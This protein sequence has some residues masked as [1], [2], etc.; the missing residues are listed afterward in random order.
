MPAPSPPG[1]VAGSDT[2]GSPLQD[3]S[4]AVPGA[5]A[6]CWDPPFCAA[7][8]AFC[9]HGLGSV[10][11]CLFLPSHPR[12]GLPTLPPPPFLRPPVSPGPSRA[13]KCVH[14]VALRVHVP[15]PR[16]AC[17]APSAQL[18]HR[19][20]QAPLPLSPSAVQTWSLVQ[21]FPLWS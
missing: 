11:V 13:C 16:P 5:R 20:D 8:A 21:N 18:A 1:G 17:P 9:L 19:R 10:S 2:P 15:L 6:S 4:T 7:Q 14:S 12:A 3:L